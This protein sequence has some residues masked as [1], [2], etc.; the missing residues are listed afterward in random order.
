MH[1][2]WVGLP[3]AHYSRRRTARVQGISGGARRRAWRSISFQSSAPAGR[4]RDPGVNFGEGF[5]GGISGAISVKVDMLH[6]TYRINRGARFNML[7]DEA[8]QSLGILI[9][10]HFH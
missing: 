9:F 7:P 5:G 2:T 8:L 3:A 10:D 1:L 4:R 6:A